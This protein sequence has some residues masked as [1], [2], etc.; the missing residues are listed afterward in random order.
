MNDGNRYRP[1]NAAA[2]LPD[3][4]SR[5]PLARGE[6]IFAWLLLINGGLGVLFLVPTMLQSSVLALPVVLA[7]PLAGVVAG[8]F[9]LRQRTWAFF[10]GTLFYLVQCARYYSPALNVGFESGLQVSF[11]LHP[12]EDETLEINLF[13][14]AALIWGMNTLNLRWM[15]Q[16]KAKR[17]CVRPAEADSL[18]E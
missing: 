12:A 17:A 15:A 3:A 5:E 18:G 1:P 9:A 14:I 6:A 11:A 8:A 13:A 2:L 16:E 7:V 10:V 4:A